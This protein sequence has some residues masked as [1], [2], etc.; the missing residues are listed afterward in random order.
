MRPQKST[1]LVPFFTTKI[2]KVQT[3]ARMLARIAS[4]S[5]LLGVLLAVVRV[6]HESVGGSKLKLRRLAQHTDRESEED[7]MAHI[8]GGA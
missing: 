6:F 4:G 5:T 7:N 3:A 1:E 2:G 8:I